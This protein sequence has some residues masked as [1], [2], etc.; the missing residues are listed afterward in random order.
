[1]KKQIRRCVFETNSS[2]T[3]S[4][5]MCLKSDYDAWQ[6]GTLLYDGNKFISVEEGQKENA[7]WLR[8]EGIPEEAIEDY[9]KGDKTL[10]D[11]C[12]E[13]LMSRWDLYELWR[14][15]VEDEYYDEE[16]YNETFFQSFTTPSGEVVVAFGEYGYNG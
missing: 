2:S 10:V 8:K 13:D 16:N 6:N 7:E 15:D 1:M 14:S 4:M 12:E 5:T 3:H 11:L 9:L